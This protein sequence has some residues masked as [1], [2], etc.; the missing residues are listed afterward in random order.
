[1]ASTV[2][3]EA[4]RHGVP[5]AVLPTP[6]HGYVHDYVQRGA[7]LGLILD[8][9]LEGALHRLVRPSAAYSAAIA[10]YVRT[11][12]AFPHEATQ[13]VGELMMGLLHA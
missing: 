7:A 8:E 4:L 1:M 10:E 12:L 5:L 3:L 13:R 6:G 9:S 2:G 11:H